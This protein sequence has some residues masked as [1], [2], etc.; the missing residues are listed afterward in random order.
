MA[1]FSPNGF[2]CTWAVSLMN[3]PLVQVSLTESNSPYIGSYLPTTCD[4]IVT[5][6]FDTQ[7][8]KPNM[9][10]L[11]DAKRLVGM[12]VGPYVSG[13]CNPNWGRPDVDR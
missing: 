13:K 3:R 5:G 4:H 11:M 2:I 12:K 7:H 1:A 10:E 8:F 9:T 6:E